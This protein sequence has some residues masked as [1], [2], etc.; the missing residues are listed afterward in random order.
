MQ[1]WGHAL[2][3]MRCVPSEGHTG[4]FANS[5]VSTQGI[6]HD[7]T[8]SWKHITMVATQ[9]TPPQTGLQADDLV[10]SCRLISPRSHR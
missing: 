2:R 1:D 10:A 4:S 9:A 3:S 5:T 8:E 7:Y 6:A